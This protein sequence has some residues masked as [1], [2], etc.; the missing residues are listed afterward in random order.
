LP[1]SRVLP[2]TTKESGKKWKLSFGAELNSSSAFRGSDMSDD[3]PLK[4]AVDRAWTVHIATHNDVDAADQR[5]CSLERY[6]AGKWQAGESDPEELT[7]HGLSYLA[8]VG[9]DYD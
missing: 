1:S 7:C 6:L 5:R 3:Y 4:T 2:P 9:S 8:R